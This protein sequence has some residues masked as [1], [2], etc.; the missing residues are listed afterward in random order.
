MICLKL[1]KQDDAMA[2]IPLDLKIWGLEAP[3]AAT[4]A[5]NNGHH[6]VNIY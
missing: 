4:T 3:L 2:T 1:K 6:T 5:Y